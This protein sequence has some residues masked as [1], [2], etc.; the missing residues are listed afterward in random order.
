MNTL[1]TKNPRSRRRFIAATAM[2]AAVLASAGAFEGLA[3]TRPAPGNRANAGASGA[4]VQP[5]RHASN[6]G[7]AATRTQIGQPPESARAQRHRTGEY[8]A[9]RG[10]RPNGPKEEENEADN[11]EAANGYSTKPLVYR[12]GS[13]IQTIPRIYLVLWGP[14]WFS[15]G[16]PDG[17]A[18]RLHYFY[19]AVGGSPWANVL[20][21]Y[22]GANGAFLNPTGQYKGWLQD[23]TPVPAQPT[24]A[25]V[26]AAAQRAA[27]RVNDHDGN[28]QF[29]VATPYGVVDQKSTANSFCGWH[30]YSAVGSSYFTYTSLPYA[31]YLD[32]LGRHCGG[33][34][35]NSNGKLDGVTILAGHEYAETVND[36]FLN[37]WYD[38]DKS[39]NADKCSWVNLRN[40]TL[41]A[42]YTFPVQPTWGN[43]WQKSYGY[44]CYY[45]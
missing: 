12:G 5:A 28:V 31:P 38:A 6:A 4:V 21:Q 37:T 39:E 18:N 43:A 30:D 2:T 8:P 25:Q 40:Y 16:D 23:T 34:K 45:S 20:K 9:W 29:V 15:G 17:V 27:V 33:Y 42:G 3:G 32:A 14:T 19:T 26:A 41:A 1:V 35:V 24:A 10:G 22:T 36:P 7:P 11:G 44:G 13:G